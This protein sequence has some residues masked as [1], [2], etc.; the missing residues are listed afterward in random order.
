MQ[1]TNRRRKVTAHAIDPKTD[2]VTGKQR[3]LCGSLIPDHAVPWDG[4][5]PKDPFCLKI[6]KDGPSK[7]RQRRLRKLNGQG[8]PDGVFAQNGDGCSVIRWKG[9]EMS[10]DKILPLG[11][12]ELKV[13]AKSVAVYSGGKRVLFKRATGWTPGK[14]GGKL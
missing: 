7:R 13:S 5:T 4:K 11:P 2:K 3:T 10:V 14:M 1:W 12:Y 8:A 9:K 6:I